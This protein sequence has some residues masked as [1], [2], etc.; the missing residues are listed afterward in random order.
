MW[1]RYGFSEDE[2][3]R[4]GWKSVA[5]GPANVQVGINT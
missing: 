3:A 2:I 5:I 1:R 4:I